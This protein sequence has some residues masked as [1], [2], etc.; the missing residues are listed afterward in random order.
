[1]SR[2][3]KSFGF[4]L[5]GILY[6]VKTQGNFKLHLAAATIVVFAGCYFNL[7]STDWLWLILAMGLVLMAELF[8]TALEILVDFI[9]PTYH[10][11]AGLV[12]DTAA[13]AVLIAA[14]TAALIGLII[15][16]PKI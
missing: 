9:S 15:F 16:I 1:M 3:L 11:K 8:N 5:N 14:I 2:F 4:A 7:A 13:A 12:K 6:A 10:K